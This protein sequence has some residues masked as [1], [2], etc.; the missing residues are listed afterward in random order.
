[1]GLV[2]RPF[3]PA[4]YPAAVTVVNAVEPDWP[5]TV[6]EWRFNDERQD[7]RCRWGR[8][9][10]E[11]DGAVVGLGEYSQPPERF[12]PRKFWVGVC[13]RPESEGRGIGA[14]LYEGLLEALAP[15]EPLV[16]RANTREDR[17]RALRFLEQRGFRECMREW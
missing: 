12:D 14:A 11:R 4:D 6:D 8:L 5:I 17:A 2:V 1:M 13:V 7:P 15:L 16:L 10:A 9:V 3:T